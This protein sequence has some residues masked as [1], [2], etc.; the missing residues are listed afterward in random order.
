MLNLT[1]CILGTFPAQGIIPEQRATYLPVMKALLKVMQTSQPS[2]QDLN[3]LMGLTR[4][5][6]KKVPKGETN[7]LGNLGNLLGNFGFGDLESMGLPES[8]D[9]VMD[10]DAVPHVRTSFG[11]CFHFCF[12][13]IFCLVLLN[14]QNILV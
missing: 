10:I 3:T 6:N 8:G 11:K 14:G 9:I 7:L 13:Q 5:L 2:S 12:N 4:E 1:S